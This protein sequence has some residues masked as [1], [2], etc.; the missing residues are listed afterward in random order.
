MR[1]HVRRSETQV[2]KLLVACNAFH[3]PLPPL[4]TVKADTS[5][6]PS[7]QRKLEDR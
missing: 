4:R 5:L 1:A 6:P 3:A 2:F 7:M